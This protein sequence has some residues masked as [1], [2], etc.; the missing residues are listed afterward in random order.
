[1]EGAC[2]ASALAT[3]D[4]RGER[5]I[6]IKKRKAEVNRESMRGKGSGSDTGSKGEKR[7]KGSPVPTIKGT[8]SIKKKKKVDFPRKHIR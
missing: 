2:K 3:L 8:P 6:P 1:L 5:R 7:K 4:E